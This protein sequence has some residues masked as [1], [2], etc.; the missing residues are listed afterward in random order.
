M[1]LRQQGE[2]QKKS[3]ALQN[4]SLSSVITKEARIFH[5]LH[6]QNSVGTQPTLERLKVKIKAT[7]QENSRTAK[8]G[9]SWPQKVWG[10]VINPM[11]RAWAKAW[12]PLDGRLGPI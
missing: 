11:L 6:K 12:S 5:K 3:T 1:D 9:A 4:G 8:P 2:I 10:P 7:M